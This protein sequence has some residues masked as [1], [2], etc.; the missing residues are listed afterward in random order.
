MLYKVRFRETCLYSD[1]LNHDEFVHSGLPL[2]VLPAQL[3]TR[4]SACFH[5]SVGVGGIAQE[6]DD[7]VTVVC[8]SNRNVELY[9][10]IH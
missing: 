5:K 9:H 6:R 4:I 2:E 7:D 3:H 10:E 1:H 8:I